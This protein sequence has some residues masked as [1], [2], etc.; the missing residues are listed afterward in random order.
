[1]HPSLFPI[2][3][4]VAPSQNAVT[5]PVQNLQEEKYPVKNHL[6]DVDLHEQQAG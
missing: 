1:L 3:G 4:G 6:R 5:F 2:G